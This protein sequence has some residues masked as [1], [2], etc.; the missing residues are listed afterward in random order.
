MRVFGTARD[1]R[2]RARRRLARGGILLSLGVLLLLTWLLLHYFSTDSFLAFFLAGFGG[3]L[4][5]AWGIGSLR[6]GL[7]MTATPTAAREVIRTL[8]GA[9]DD[10]YVL[11]R[12]VSLP[13]SGAF[14]DAILL[15]PHGALVLS[16]Q[17]LQGTYLHR[18]HRWY[19]LTGDGTPRLLDRS[20]TWDLTRPW[21]SAR[22]LVREYAV[23][24][25]PV[26]AA[27][28]LASGSLAE[29]EGGP[30]T[31]PEGPSVENGASSQA[32]PADRVTAAA[33]RALELAQ[34]RPAPQRSRFLRRSVE[35]DHP[36][37]P[38]ITGSEVVALVQALPAAERATPELV[39]ELADALRPRVG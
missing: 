35:A 8:A 25:F 7:A 31:L 13:P 3:I 17:A 21:K 39:T 32:V 28:V 19:R 22:R 24:G 6:R 11:L 37:F 30:T 23:A 10:S 5:C 12:Q 36:V 2:R 14:A 1:I 15:G 26:S 20:P 4:S 34:A 33:E 16:L 18:K 38:V 29:S 27:V 9:L